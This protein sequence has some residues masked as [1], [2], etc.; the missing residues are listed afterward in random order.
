MAA[1]GEKPVAVDSRRA[2]RSRSCR[3]TTTPHATAPLPRTCQSAHRSRRSRPIRQPPRTASR[4]PDPRRPGDHRRNARL[5]TRT[6][7]R[8]H[9]TKRG[10]TRKDLQL[11]ELHG[12]EGAHLR[13]DHPAEMRS[14]ARRPAD[15]HHGINGEAP[16]HSAADG[17]G[18]ADAPAPRESPRGIVFRNAEVEA[19]E[20][21]LLVEQAGSPRT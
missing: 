17:R 18:W 3:A 10:R 4:R 19:R 11:L 13:V 6:E 12:D 7:R 15:R 14:P 1:D 8:H 5:E 2:T 9:K 21:E 20:A 16:A